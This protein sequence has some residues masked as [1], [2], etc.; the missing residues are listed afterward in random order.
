MMVLVQSKNP[1][2]NSRIFVEFKILPFGEF[3]QIPEQEIIEE[4]VVFY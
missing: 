1:S 4:E 2:A 3:P